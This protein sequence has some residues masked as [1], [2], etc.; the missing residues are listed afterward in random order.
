MTTLKSRGRRSPNCARHVF[1]GSSQSRINW[2][3]EK[4]AETLLLPT[5]DEYYPWEVR[6]LNKPDTIARYMRAAKWNL[7][8]GKKRLKAT[9]EWRREFKPD[10][11][12]PN[13]VK[14]ESETGKMWVNVQ[15]CSICVN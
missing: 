12:P 7:A 14:I 11:I 4:Y 2:N 1:F 15:T 10:L 5:I 6:W 9:L 3:Y 13:E 8:D